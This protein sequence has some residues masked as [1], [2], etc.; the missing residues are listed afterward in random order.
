MSDVETRSPSKRTQATL[1]PAFLHF[2]IGGFS[3]HS[4]ELAWTEGRRWLREH[5]HGYGLLKSTS[6]RPYSLPERSPWGR[7]GRLLD[8]LKLWDWPD[9][10]VDNNVLDGTQWS[11]EIHWK[12][13]RQ[14]TY[15]SNAFPDGF[16]RLER[17]LRRL[18]STIDASNDEVEYMP[19]ATTC[20]D[21]LDDPST[22]Q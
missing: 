8:D 16:D 7:F 6:W 4:W 21:S 10:F 5:A 20:R 2:H 22:R 12:G 15:G 3:G 17:A 9:T 14:K 18:A 19:L 1:P 11:I 13:Q